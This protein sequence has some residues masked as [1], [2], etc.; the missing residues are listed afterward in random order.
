MFPSPNTNRF[1]WPV[2][3][4]E[5]FSLYQLCM[6]RHTKTYPISHI[7]YFDSHL[8]SCGKLVIKTIRA[9]CWSVVT[10]SSKVYLLKHI[11]QLYQ[12]GEQSL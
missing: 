2:T 5:I 7:L 11:C 1:H 8:N 4:S 6:Y 3:A 12:T 9:K 10:D